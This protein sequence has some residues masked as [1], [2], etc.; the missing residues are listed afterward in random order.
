MRRFWTI[1]FP[2]LSPTTFFLLVVNIVY[3]FFDTF[4]II[5][6]VTGGGPA[7]ATETL[8]YKVYV[9][10][11]LGGD[12][13]GSAA[14]SVILMI[15]VDRAHR[16]PVPLRRAQG[17]RTD[18]RDSAAYRNFV[19]HLILWLGIVIV[20]FPVYL[21]L[22]ASTHDAGDHRQRPDAADAGRPLPSRTTTARIFVGTAPTTREP[23]GTMLLNS[24]VMALGI[25]VGKIA[26]SILSAYR[27]RVLPLPVP[28]GGVLGDLHHA[29]AAGRGAHLPD[30]QGRRRPRPARHLC[31]A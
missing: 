18:G 8:V 21:A 30:L 12:L 15:I 14:Q 26:I 2:L 17:A 31:R 19:P 1:I 27:R 6:A 4:G 20:A 9:D 28:H 11:R 23:V 16:D 25:A 3:A 5:D 13:G 10:G 22:V 24:L 29:D 7:K